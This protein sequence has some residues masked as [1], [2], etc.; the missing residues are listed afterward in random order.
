M[1]ES[2]DIEAPVTQKSE[3]SSVQLMQKLKHQL[4]FYFSDA[5][6]V[7]DRFMQAQL[8]KT[9]DG[10]VAL[11][12]L[13]TFGR[14]KAMTQD[15]QVLADSINDSEVLELNEDKTALKRRIAFDK[16]SC[17]DRSALTVLVSGLPEGESWEQILLFF[18]SLTFDTV[19]GAEK[20]T[21]KVALVKR[22]M[23]AEK[24][25]GT[26]FVE[27]VSK[28][29]VDRLRAQKHIKY[30]DNVQLDVKA[31]GKSD[32][33]LK[34]EQKQKQLDACREK[35]RNSTCKIELT[36]YEKPADQ[37]AE[38]ENKEKDDPAAV[39]AAAESEET[40]EIRKPANLVIDIKNALMERC[41]KCFVSLNGDGE[42]QSG[43]VRFDNTKI[44]DAIAAVNKTDA[45]DN[46]LIVQE[47]FIV[48]LSPLEDAEFEEFFE[49]NKEHLLGSG[50]LK[51]KGG[52]RGGRGGRGGRAKRSRD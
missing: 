40:K 45:N 51:R 47:K 14:V 43:I 35:T 5:N 18:N 15:L 50:S 2:A 10:F 32:R 27:L 9:S 33:E 44:D 21:V 1:V 39:E 28:T 52:N 11:S 13:A 36:P 7:R 37:V 24:F 16:D 41:G 29:D 46:Q 26:V 30:S 38:E 23:N 4:E 49:S 25:T 12:V 3:P 31:M 19:D 34:K 20:E 22:K 48:K 42:K 8:E 17:S 6:L